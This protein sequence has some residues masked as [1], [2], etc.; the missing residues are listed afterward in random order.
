MKEMV[1]GQEVNSRRAMMIRISL[2]RVQNQL[3]SSIG[4]VS[5]DVTFGT[6]FNCFISILFLGSMDTLSDLLDFRCLLRVFFDFTS[7]H[8]LASAHGIPSLAVPCSSNQ[9]QKDSIIPMPRSII[10]LRS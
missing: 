5:V 9:T 2:F 8:S 4:F 10:L 7:P 1:E 6:Y 3:F